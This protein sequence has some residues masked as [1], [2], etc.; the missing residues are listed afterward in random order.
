MPQP[1]PQSTAADVFTAPGQAL[2]QQHRLPQSWRR[3]VL[4]LGLALLLWCLQRSRSPWRELAAGVGLT[5]MTLKPNQLLLAPLVLALRSA[6][7]GVVD[8]SVRNLAM[9]TA[10][11]LHHQRQGD[12]GQ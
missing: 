5:L 2:S 7:E 11:A 6:G 8:L 1:S 3:G 12:R 10:M 9:S 4:S